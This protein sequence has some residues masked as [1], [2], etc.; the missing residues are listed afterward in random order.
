MMGFLWWLI[1]LIVS[2]VLNRRMAASKGRRKWLWTLWAVLIGL[3]STILLLV[4][5]TKKPMKACPLCTS[6][7]P[8]AAIRCPKCQGDLRDVQGGA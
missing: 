1:G 4:F 5:P 3:F 8:A 2:I 6:T 7:I